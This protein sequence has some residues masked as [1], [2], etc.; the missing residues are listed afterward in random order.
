MNTHHTLILILIIISALCLSALSIPMLRIL[1]Y[2][3]FVGYSYS[4][5]VD[6]LVFLLVVVSYWAI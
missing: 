2:A 5:I 1:S 4:H 6:S 3:H